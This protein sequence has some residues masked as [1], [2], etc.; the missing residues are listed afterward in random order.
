MAE[1]L[2]I[3]RTRSR[4]NTTDAIWKAAK[5]IIWIPTGTSP[6]LQDVL[7]KFDSIFESAT[8]GTSFSSESTIVDEVVDTSSM[9]HQEKKDCWK[10]KDFRKTFKNVVH[11]KSSSSY[12]CS[13]GDITYSWWLY[14]TSGQNDA[15]WLA[16]WHESS[17]VYNWI[18]NP[19]SR[20]TF[21]PYEWPSSAEIAGAFS[22]LQP[23]NELLEDSFSLANFMIELK[24]LRALAGLGSVINDANFDVGSSNLLTTNQAESSASDFLGVNFGVLPVIGD[25][26]KALVLMDKLEGYLDRWNEFAKSA[27]VLDFH[28]TIYN[29]STSESSSGSESYQYVDYDITHQAHTT[30]K[31][32]AH[33]Y[34]VPRPVPDAERFKVKY[35]ALGL[36]NLTGI[37]WEAIPFSWAIDYFLNIQEWV[38]Q[39]RGIDSLLKFDIVS[40]GISVLNK[41]EA[42]SSAVPTGTSHT[43]GT[44]NC[45][46]VANAV[47][48]VWQGDEEYERER[49]D[50]QLARVIID[51]GTK[52]EF[53]SDGPSPHQ[54]TL[55]AA[56]GVGMNISF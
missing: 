46:A 30:R 54:Q 21:V 2:L 33:L 48:T 38:E 15:I 14:T 49:I 4:S 19:I 39:F 8:V 10:L 6:T 9:T 53:W 55:M 12:S 32:K 31:A 11:T 35:K 5:G 27:T 13:P 26:K 28:T 18:K 40:S 43:I 29:R 23:D 41:N 45:G 24:D 37:V 51:D 47:H 56:V 7:D 50:P 22:R 42:Y 17:S 44:A 34:V 25:I 52:W 3:P 36:D 1:C 20:F 16:A